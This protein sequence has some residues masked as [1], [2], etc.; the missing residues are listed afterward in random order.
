VLAELAPVAFVLA[1]VGPAWLLAERRGLDPLR[2]HGVLARPTGLGP[3]TLVTLVLLG[4]FLAVVALLGTPVQPPPAADALVREGLAALA[5]GALFIALPEEW[6]YRGVLQPALD[7]PRKVRL[8]GA[9]VGRGL[10]LAALLF[11]VAHGLYD[12][13]DTGQVTPWRLLTAVPALLFGW[14]RARTGSVLVAASAHALADALE[15]AAR[16]GWTLP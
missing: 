5:W 8:L 1:W 10:L 7:G 11:G 6:L 12:L 3:A 15:R 4:G 2:A 13:A 9:D 16:D 14:L